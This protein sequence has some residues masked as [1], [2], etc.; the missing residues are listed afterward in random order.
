VPGFSLLFSRAL[1]NGVGGR[2]RRLAWLD[3]GIAAAFG[4]DALRGELEARLGRSDTRRTLIG[5]PAAPSR[6]RLATVPDIDRT[7]DIEVTAV[8]GMVS[9]EIPLAGHAS[10]PWLDFFRRLASKRWPGPCPVAEV[11]EREDRTWVILGLPAATALQ[12]ESEL[13]AVIALISE[14]TGMEQ[15]SQ[16][17]AAEIEAAI[18]RWWARQQR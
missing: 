11:A 7:A 16:S 14:A 6:G 15:Q 2:D 10:G 13:D 8:P 1:E 18:R 17:G 3:D 4:E 5:Q 12:P 9:A